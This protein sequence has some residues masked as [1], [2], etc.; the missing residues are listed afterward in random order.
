MQ[1]PSSRY[2]F[3]VVEDRHEPNFV[4]VTEGKE[5]SGLNAKGCDL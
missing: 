2:E 4:G 1:A 3:C 5:G